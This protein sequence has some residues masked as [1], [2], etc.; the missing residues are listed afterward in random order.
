MLRDHLSMHRSGFYQPPTIIHLSL[1]DPQ[2]LTSSFGPL[3]IR[4][5]GVFGCGRCLTR[6]GA[7]VGRW[8]RS[9]VR[10]FT[11]VISNIP[12]GPFEV[13]RTMGNKL[14]QFTRTIFAF[15]QG[16]VG[17]FLNDLFNFAALTALILI[18]R[19]FF[20]FPP[21]FKRSGKHSHQKI[22]LNIVC[23]FGLSRQSYR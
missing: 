6:P 10:G 11:G 18:D 1:C 5:F 14:V 2:S 3:I 15:G 9:V 16:L 20:Q 13:K 8:I 21:D 4:D 19:H 23:D 17:K 22:W 12:T 7:L